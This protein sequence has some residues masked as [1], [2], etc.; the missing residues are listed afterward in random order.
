[1]VGELDIAPNEI[2]WAE[3]EEE[4]RRIQAADI[5][6]IHHSTIDSHLRLSEYGKISSL[7]PRKDGML[8]TISRHVFFSLSFFHL[9]L[10][11]RRVFFATL[12]P[13]KA[14]PPFKLPATF[15]GSSF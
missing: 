5:I 10:S 15:P 14:I 8:I 13:A 6:G 11:D 9:E 3:I 1:M 2:A 7:Q 4:P 12:E